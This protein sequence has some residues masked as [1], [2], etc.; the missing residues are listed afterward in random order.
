MY[1]VACVILKKIYNN[2]KIMVKKIEIKKLNVTGF[3]KIGHVVQIIE[4]R[5]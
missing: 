2:N 5:Y 4:L 1:V 3:R